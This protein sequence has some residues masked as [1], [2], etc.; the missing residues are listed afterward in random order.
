M[1]IKI[2]KKTAGL[3]KEGYEEIDPDMNLILRLNPLVMENKPA[4]GVK[5]FRLTG[6]NE[7]NLFAWSKPNYKGSL[8]RTVNPVFEVI[9]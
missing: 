3:H 2:V 8:L 4:G 9:E 5:L 7:K 6:L 1:K